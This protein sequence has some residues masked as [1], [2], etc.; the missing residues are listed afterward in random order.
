MIGFALCGS[1]CTCAASLAQ[2]E[3]LIGLGYD[4]GAG[5]A[6]IV[7]IL[8]IYRNTCKSDGEDSVLMENGGAHV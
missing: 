7:C 1:F 3:T 4:H 8:D 5:S 2:M 6:G